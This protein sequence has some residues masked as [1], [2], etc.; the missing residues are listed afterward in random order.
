MK[1]HL[2]RAYRRRLRHSVK[3][4]LTMIGE[5]VRQVFGRAATGQTRDRRYKRKRKSIRRIHRP[6]IIWID[7]RSEAQGLHIINDT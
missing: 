4:R 3:V 2:S 1:F 7:T 6:T 5:P